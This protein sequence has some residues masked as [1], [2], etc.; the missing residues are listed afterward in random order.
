MGIVATQSLKNM[1]TT[2]LGFAIGAVNTLVLYVHF[3]KDEDYGLVSFLLSAASIL[4]PVLAFGVHSTIVKF[5]T[6][7]AKKDQDSF[8]TLMLALPIAVI[9]P[10]TAILILFYDQIADFLT[11]ENEVVAPYIPLIFLIGIAMAYFEVFYAWARIQLQSVMGN[12]MK[13]V[14]H[15]FAVTLLLILFAMNWIDFKAFMALLGV[16]YGLRT[17][18]MMFYAFKLKKPRFVLVFPYE[19]NDEGFFCLDTPLLKE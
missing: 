18:I 9:I 8:L 2:Y 4:M 13:E 14:F 19:I 7:Y 5:Y 6:A 11:T 12:F 16:S 10:A 1:I 17:V 15:R 3:F